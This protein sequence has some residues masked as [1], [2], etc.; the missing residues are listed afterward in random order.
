M[1]FSY[2]G[3]LTDATDRV[4]F[5]IGDIVSG[6]GPRPHATSTNFSNEEV[7]AIVTEQG[8]WGPAAAKLMEI[9]ANEWA[10]AAGNVAMADYSENYTA[11]AE[12]F[13]K[14]AQD[15]RMQYGGGVAVSQVSVT[16]VDGYSDDVD[17]EE[18]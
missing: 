2:G 4:R 14:R 3:T 8:G 6:S 9:L 15:L 12:Y 11:R 1:T 16:R 17:A 13:R 18:V 10:S 7:D 5:E